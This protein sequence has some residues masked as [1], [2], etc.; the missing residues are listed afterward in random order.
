MHQAFKKHN[1][2]WLALSLACSPL[3]A[4]AT[5]QPPQELVDA[6][7]AYTRAQSGYARELSPASLHTA[8]QALDSAEK[9]FED[10]GASDA[11]RDEA[12]I[13]LR[14]AQLA[15]SDGSTAHLQRQLAATKERAH[16]AESRAAQKT[17]AEL[18]QTREQLA[19]EQSAREAAEKRAQDLTQRLQAASAAAA[20]K[21][22]TRG[23]VITLP[24]NVLFASGKSMLLPGAQSALNQ[25]ADALKDQSDTKILVEG[26]TDSTGS[27]QTN[28]ELSKARAEAVASYLTSRGVPKEQ[29]TSEGYGPSRPVADNSTPEG[30]ANNRRVEIVV[31]QQEQR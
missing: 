9:R 7:A 11:V 24:G 2:S 15:E 30:R 1:A 10:D 5:S 12:Y 3:L 29:V 21:Q 4:C 16:E 20:V 14:K 6:R 23:T 8:K 17:Q 26:H 31:Q 19:K 27:Q 28:T 25:V 18:A 13:A 22:E